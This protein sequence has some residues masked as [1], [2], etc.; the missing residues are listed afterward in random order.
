MINPIV[1]RWPIGAT[2]DEGQISLAT[3]PD[4]YSIVLFNDLGFT[5]EELQCDD[6]DLHDR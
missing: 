1:L 2:C 4:S 6:K 3:T 5:Y